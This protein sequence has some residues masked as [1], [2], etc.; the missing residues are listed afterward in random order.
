MFVTCVVVTMVLI[1]WRTVEDKDV[2]VPM[3][4]NADSV[5]DV[6]ENDMIFVVVEIFAVSCPAPPSVTQSA[7]MAPININAN[8]ARTKTI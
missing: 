7:T 4:L 5:I 3:V 1:V 2:V 8:S 6:V